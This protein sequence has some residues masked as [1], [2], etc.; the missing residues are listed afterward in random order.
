MKYFYWYS[1]TVGVYG[2]IIIRGDIDVF[3]GWLT[4]PA[5]ASYASILTPRE[6]S[7]NLVL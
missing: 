2:Q 6:Y 7:F 3:E 1:F 4:N 5:K